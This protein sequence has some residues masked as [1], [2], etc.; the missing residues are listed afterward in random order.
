MQFL[1][2]ILMLV[3][4]Y[5]CR[6]AEIKTD[7]TGP[8]SD[9]TTVNADNMSTLTDAEKAE[10]WELLFDDNSIK[11]WHIFNNRSDGSAWIRKDGAI[12]LDTS[13][14]TGRGDLITD[15]VY[16]DF[17]LKLEWKIGKGGNSGIIFYVQDDPKYGATYHTG[18][19][20]QVLDN[21]AHADAK[22]I[23]HRA[24][25]LYDLITGEPESV[26]PVG[27]WNAVEIKSKGGTLEFYL[28][29]NKIVTTTMWD[30]NWRTMIANSK[31]KAWPD[32]GTFKEGHIALQDHGDPVWYRNVKI[33]RL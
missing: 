18:P 8:E 13:N 15:A 22:I 30:E 21:T 31:F 19:E 5:I 23:K 26:K 27:E 2:T 20:M 1:A 10:G 3:S 11:G 17:D 9:S 28:N 16:G 33:R 12:T 4:F 32:F 24:G 7:N 6:S 14:K 25:D 29:G